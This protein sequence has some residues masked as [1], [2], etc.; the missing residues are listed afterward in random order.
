MTSANWDT[1]DTDLELSDKNSKMPR[2]CSPH[3]VYNL[4]I[5]KR[6]FKTLL[7]YFVGKFRY[8]IDVCY[9]LKCGL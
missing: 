9:P 5:E 7:N 3:L 8:F 2:I 1:T 6:R 4:Q